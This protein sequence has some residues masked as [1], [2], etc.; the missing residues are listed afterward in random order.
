MSRCSRASVEARR[1][2]SAFLDKYVVK[3]STYDAAL[4][5]YLDKRVGPASRDKDKAVAELCEADCRPTLR[6]RAG[7]AVH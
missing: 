5:A 6:A 3:S 4:L 2:F 1:R 7:G